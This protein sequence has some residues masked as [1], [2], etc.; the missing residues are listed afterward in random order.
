MNPHLIRYVMSYY[1][2]FMNEVERRA[3]S[4]L[5][6]TMKATMGCSDDGAQQE[7]RH[8]RMFA[9][10]L[11]DDRLVLQLTSQGYQ[12]FAERT[13][14]RVF[15]EHENDIF[16]NLCPRCH[17]LARTPTAKQCRFCGF[18]WHPANQSARE[19]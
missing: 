14:N 13:A 18:D 6:G 5:G 10:F 15:V 11:S 19:N 16:L 9:R 3:Y 4:H 1:S 12:A 8:N 2:S 17:E 7:A